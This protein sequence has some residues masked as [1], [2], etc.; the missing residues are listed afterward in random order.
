MNA[1]PFCGSWNYMIKEG[2]IIGMAGSQSWK[3]FVECLDCKA[4]GPELIDGPF[5]SD[6]AR[7]TCVEAWNHRK[8]LALRQAISHAINY[9]GIDAKLN[10]AEHKIADLLVGEVSK[11]LRG[12]TDVQ[13]VECMTPEER[14]KI[15][16]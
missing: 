12:Q 9:H 16:T 2:P 7:D 13:I 14:A 1:C 5:E 3:I 6:N 10:M 11:H 4:R 8:D 15:G